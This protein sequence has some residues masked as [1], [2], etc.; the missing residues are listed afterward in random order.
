MVLG[1][2]FPYVKSIILE[3]VEQIITYRQIKKSYCLQQFY[4]PPRTIG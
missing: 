1:V 4:P 2:F 3:S